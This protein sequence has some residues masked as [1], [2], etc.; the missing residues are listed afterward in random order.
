MSDF[1]VKIETFTNLTLT[2][3][4]KARDKIMEKC[5]SE[6]KAT[7][8]AYTA[9]CE[10][11]FS[12]MLKENQVKISTENHRSVS[13]EVTECKKKIFSHREM[14]I[15]KLFDALN[16]K[17][18]EF[19][20]SNE[21]KNYLEQCI[22]KGIETVGKDNLLLTFDTS[23]KEIGEE[24]SKN[25]NAEVNFKDGLVGGVIVSAKMC[26]V[27]CNMSI[28]ASIEN[29]KETFLENSGFSIDVM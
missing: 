22:L 17:I 27:A 23:D 16:D 26:A 11:K 8:A 12:K 3:A 1:D 20:K 29:L 9:E 2:Q 28:Q 7:L 21:Y 14:L 6:K 4:A 19:K 24:F 18:S 13:K 15:G 25:Y 5:E 10:E